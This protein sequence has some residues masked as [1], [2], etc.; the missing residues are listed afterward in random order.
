MQLETI[1][2][3]EPAGGTQILTLRPA[4]AH[5]ECWSG[6]NTSLDRRVVDLNRKR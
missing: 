6:A 2:G 4:D 1:G 3:S 5:K